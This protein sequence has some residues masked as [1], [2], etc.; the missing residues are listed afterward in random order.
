MRQVGRGGD[1]LVAD[2]ESRRVGV[3]R[4]QPEVRSP[5]QECQ[6]LGLALLALQRANAI[7]QPPAGLHPVRRRIQQPVLVLGSWAGYQQYGATKASTQAIFA[8][9]YAALPHKTIELSA[10]G[11][12]FIM[13][14]DTQWLYNQTDAFLKSLPVVAKK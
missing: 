8:A 1:Y 9:Q 3:R 11:K 13:Y 12:H 10:A 2:Q 14:D 7:D 6:N 5:T 4:R